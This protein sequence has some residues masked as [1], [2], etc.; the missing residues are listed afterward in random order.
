MVIVF[1]DTFYVNALLF[2]LRPIRREHI[3]QSVVARYKLIKL[4]ETRD[5]SGFQDH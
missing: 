2:A 3:I 5:T 1:W 4:Q